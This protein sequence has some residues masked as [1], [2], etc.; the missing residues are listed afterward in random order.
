MESWFAAATLDELDLTVARMLT[1]ADAGD[2]RGDEAAT[3][4]FHRT[5]VTAAGHPLLAEV[6]ESLL[7]A[8]VTAFDAAGG[9][10]D[11]SAAARSHGPIVDAIRSGDAALAEQRSREHAHQFEIGNPA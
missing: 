6:W 5:I 11:R 7:H 10:R 2:E 4:D 8:S 3:V 9:T 1:A